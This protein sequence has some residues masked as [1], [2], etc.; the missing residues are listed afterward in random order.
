[1]HK[2]VLLEES[3]ENLNLNDNSTIVDCT[4][5]YGGHSTEILKHIPK[6]FL[7]AFDQDKEAIN[8]AYKRLKEAGSNFEIINTNFKNIKEEI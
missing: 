4:L 7:Y 1:M 5:G 2:S 3:I 8:E 6:G